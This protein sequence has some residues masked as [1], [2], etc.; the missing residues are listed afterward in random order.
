ML[1][2]PD[3]RRSRRAPR[4]DSQRSERS[5]WSIDI[6]SATHVLSV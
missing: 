6:D 1:L 5:E 2:V 4:R 3:R